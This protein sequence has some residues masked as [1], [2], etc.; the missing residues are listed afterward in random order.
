MKA[1]EIQP[2]PT[3]TANLCCVLALQ[4]LNRGTDKNTRE[5]AV[6]SSF[7]NLQNPSECGKSIVST[8][9]FKTNVIKL[10]SF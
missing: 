6:L 2:L 1:S 7:I 4:Y 5:I 9:I 3:I 10:I 8:Y